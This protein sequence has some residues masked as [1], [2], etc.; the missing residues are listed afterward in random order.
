MLF[1]SSG[2]CRSAEAALTYNIFESGGN[3]HIQTSGQL[4][5]PTA[6]NT[7]SCTTNGFLSGP[8]ALICSGQDVSAPVYMVSGPTTFG[9]SGDY[10]ADS[11]SGILTILNGLTRLFLIDPSYTPG[12]PIVSS[13]TFQGK[14][15]LDLGITTTGPIG[16]KLSC[17]LE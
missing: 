8:Y 7:N 15:L 14:T 13:A 10:W 17:P 3:V 4:L 2:L 9:F 1:R 11:V 5:L 6:V 12:T 16:Q